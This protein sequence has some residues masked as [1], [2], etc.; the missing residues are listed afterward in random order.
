V[1]VGVRLTVEVVR[2]SVV[3]MGVTG[4]GDSDTVCVCGGVGGGGGGGDGGG[5]EAGSSLDDPIH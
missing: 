5:D 3:A 4:V 2:V 1:S